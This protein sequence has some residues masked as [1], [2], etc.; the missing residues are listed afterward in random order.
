MD[1]FDR[2]VI[3]SLEAKEKEREWIRHQTVGEFDDTK[4]VDSIL[5]EKNIY[6]KRGK[7]DTVPGAIQKKLKHLR[8]LVDI[9]GSMY[10]FNGHDLR[11][12]RE[13]GKRICL[14]FLM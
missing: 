4:L 7:R 5:G 3:E 9:S 6:K 10:R 8:L 11:L 2:V 12:Q 13:L 14:K 1:C